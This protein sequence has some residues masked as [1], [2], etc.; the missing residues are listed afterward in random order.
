VYGW[1]VHGLT[2]ASSENLAPEEDDDED[3]AGALKS[4]FLFIA[5]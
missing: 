2:L 4:S 5:F 1:L 3:A